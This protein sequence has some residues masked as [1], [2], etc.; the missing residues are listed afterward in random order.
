M[1]EKRKSPLAKK[2]PVIAYYQP[3]FKRG[4]GRCNDYPTSVLSSLAIATH[5]VGSSSE[6]ALHLNWK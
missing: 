2:V 3:D 5:D 4:K 6:S 1:L